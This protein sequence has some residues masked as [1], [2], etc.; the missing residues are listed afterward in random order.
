MA[1]TEKELGKQMKRFRTDG[2]GEYTP[3][4]SAEYQ[5]SEGMVKETTLR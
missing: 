3:K 4:E 1:L 5:K 2:G